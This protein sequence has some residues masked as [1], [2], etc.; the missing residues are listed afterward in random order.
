MKFYTG[1]FLSIITLLSCSKDKLFTSNSDKSENLKINFVLE[2]SDLDLQA[3]TNSSRTLTPQE[4]LFNS[5]NA[6]VSDIKASNIIRKKLATVTTSNVS[7]S[8]NIKC[9]IKIREKGTSSFL[10][11]EVITNSLNSNLKLDGGKRFEYF[12]YTTNE[13]IAPPDIDASGTLSKN[14]LA[15]KDFLFDKGEFSTV[16]GNNHLDI[17]LKRKV[18]KISIE[19][20]VQGQFGTIQ[21][22]SKIRIGYLANLTDTNT[23]TNFLKIADFNIFSNSFINTT[24][25]PVN[26]EHTGSSMIKKDPNTTKEAVKIADF[27]T[28]ND[29]ITFSANSIYIKF[30]KLHI[31]VGDNH[32][33][34]VFPRSSGYFAYS[35][36]G[37]RQYDYAPMIRL[38]S[39]SLTIQE[40]VVYEAKIKTIEKGL[41]IEGTEWAR[42]D[43]Y[44]INDSFL[45][46]PYRF[47]VRFNNEYYT[48]NG[49]ISVT[50]QSNQEKYYWRYLSLTPTGA[51][52]TNINN[53]PC[54]KVLPEGKWSL[55]SVSQ[56]NA[57]RNYIVNGAT[58]PSTTTYGIE[59]ILFRTDA[60]SIL[61]KAKYSEG[62]SGVNYYQIY[63]N[64]FWTYTSD[65]SN[66]S[67]IFAMLGYLN[68]SNTLTSN[69][70]VNQYWV[71]D[72]NNLSVQYYSNKSG[73]SANVADKSSVNMRDEINTV[74]IPN[75]QSNSS[76]ASES[77]FRRS[78]RCVRNN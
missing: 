76:T 20:D 22:D 59:N 40:G 78:I 16:T 13:I 61:Y 64:N 69:N 47:L 11:N 62:N 32:R 75:L 67:L 74:N 36:T 53:D 34:R 9:R 54:R 29:G 15:Q 41:I 65:Y 42:T 58:F 30:P 49:T 50:N 10:I 45:P 25:I 48:N 31:K 63:P 37:V 51:A 12:A 68:G 33:S 70:A 4:Q 55:P 39:T 46:N 1:I 73:F 77:N 27:Y 8:P 71:Y 21:D 3:T 19:V 35:N 7:L 23:F 38:N 17:V 28:I 24:K 2:N 26:N 72:P 66:Q 5:F 56:F 18:S 57:L 14:D 60:N 44:Y 52:S 6:D 43:L